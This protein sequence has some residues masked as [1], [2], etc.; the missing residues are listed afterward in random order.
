MVEND[1]NKMS[2]ELILIAD[3]EPNVRSLIR[4]SLNK[5]GYRNII[6]AND[7]KETVEK[8]R[9]HL[10][11][12]ILIDLQLPNMDGFKTCEYIKK[13]DQFTDIPIIVISDLADIKNKAQA[14][15]CGAD[16][17]LAKPLDIITLC[18]RTKATLE[19]RRLNERLEQLTSAKS[20]S[21]YLFD[22]KHLFERLVAGLEYSRRK[23][24]PFSLVYLDID[25]L[26][27]LNMEYGWQVGDRLIKGVREIVYQVV[28]NKGI[29]IS[30]NSDKL[31]LILPGIDEDKVQVLTDD[32]MGQ[33]RQIP[34]PIEFKE[35]VALESMSRRKSVLTR[36]TLSMG[37][38]TW[39]KTQG[40]PSDKFLDLAEKA[41]ETAQNEGRD[42][43][44]QFQFYS[45]QTAGSELKIDKTEIKEYQR[46][47][48]I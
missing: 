14:Y 31:I 1:K 38:V 10:P 47:E 44:V 2:D 28:G 22:Y 39:D 11:D 25:Y 26:K 32:I 4:S 19:I 45:R 9:K 42:K 27:I 15:E 17:F 35:K 13:V 30:S 37:I 41:L 12:L 16:D 43:K 23:S 33:V 5:I 3:D 18:A 21:D 34:L 40:I 20:I 24:L 8:V 46:K 48:N 7:G 29:V 36:V 6:T